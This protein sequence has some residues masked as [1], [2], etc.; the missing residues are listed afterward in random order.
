M[1]FEAMLI[2]AG[3]WLWVTLIAVGGWVWKK[4]ETRITD[5]EKAHQEFIKVEEAK[6]MVQEM[7]EPIRTEQKDMKTDLKHILTA[8]QEIQKDMAVQAA[9]YKIQHGIKDND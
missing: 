7:I 6:K 2:A 8:V 5:L 3:K 4:Q 1:T 9:V